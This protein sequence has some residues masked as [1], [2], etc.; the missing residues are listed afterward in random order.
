MNHFLQSDFIENESPHNG[1]IFSF[2]TASTTTTEKHPALALLSYTDIANFL[3][4]LFII[5]DVH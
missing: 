1:I 5:D 3:V 4:L 2:Q